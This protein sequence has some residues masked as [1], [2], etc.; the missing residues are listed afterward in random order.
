M[1]LHIENTTKSAN[2]IGIV[3]RSA[4]K[5]LFTACAV[6]GTLGAVN[7]ARA[8]TV[9]PGSGE[10]PPVAPEVVQ[11]A[12]FPKK[13]TQMTNLTP[14]FT[15]KNGRWVTLRAQLFY[16][17]RTTGKWKPLGYK[18]VPVEFRIGSIWMGSAMTDRNGWASITVQIKDT[19]K[20]YAQGKRINWRATC[21]GDIELYRSIDSN[22]FLLMP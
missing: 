14:T 1:K 9:N 16:Q 7:N 22:R 18:S 4:L 13:K 2:S 17:E 3:R 12:G 8:Q 10:L 6:L 11:R 19:G 21:H 20:I 5:L 15:T